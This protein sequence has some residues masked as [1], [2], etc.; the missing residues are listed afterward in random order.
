MT[1]KVAIVGCGDMG[2]EHAL[3]WQQSP[4]A[5]ITAV[6]DEAGD[7]CRDLAERYGATGHARWQ[8]AIAQDGIDVVS[9]CVPV[10][11]HRDVTVAAAQAGRH[12]LC[13]K[14][15]ALTLAEADDMIVA[16]RTHGVQLAVCHQYRGFGHFKTIRDLLNQDLLGSPLHMRMTDFR[17]VRPKLAMHRRDRNGGPVHDMAGHFFDLARHL[18]GSE[19]VSVSAVGGVFGGNKPRLA[20]IGDPGIDA[21]DVQVR[22]EGG[23]GLSVSINWG[24]PEGTPDYN[25]EV[26][27]GPKGYAFTVEPLDGELPGDDTPVFRKIVLFGNGRGRRRIVNADY[28]RGPAICIADLMQSI[29]TGQPG[30]FDGR[31][32]RRAL[33]LVVAALASAESGQPVYL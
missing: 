26:F 4:D 7:R 18:T 16:A 24:L 2:A 5:T 27:S 12:I 21:A 11:L 29:R 1:L 14:P 30:A 23:H 32:G 17:E 13:E 10:C 22:F 8:D 19:A 33:E 28:P 6:C 31:A 15:M 20:G 9:V 25:G 3:A